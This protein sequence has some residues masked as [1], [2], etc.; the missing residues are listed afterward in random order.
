MRFGFRIE[1]GSGLCC[2][3]APDRDQQ[4]ISATSFK[5]LSMRGLGY[6]ALSFVDSEYFGNPRSSASP[7][8]SCCW[9]LD[10]FVF[11]GLLSTLSLVERI[12]KTYVH[13][14]HGYIS[15]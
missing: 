7:T 1:V 8:N 10:V 13:N 9:V 6:I 2:F 5:G 14:M 11:C 15:I 12:S 4:L 3:A